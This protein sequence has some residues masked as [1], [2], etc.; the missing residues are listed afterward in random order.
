MNHRVQCL[1]RSHRMLQLLA[2][3]QEHR[4]VKV[5]PST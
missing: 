4:L 3:G 1:F 5:T 2:L